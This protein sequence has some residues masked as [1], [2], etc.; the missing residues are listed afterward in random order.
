[1]PE[2]ITVD[3]AART[4]GYPALTAEDGAVGR[5]A[6]LSPVDAA[7]SHRA[8]LAQLFRIQQADQVKYVEKRP[9]LPPQLQLTLSAIDSD[10][11]SDLLNLSIVEALTRDGRIDILDADTFAVRAQDAR[12]VLYETVDENAGILATLME[13]REQLTSAIPD[14][15]A[16]YDTMHD[17]EMQL[18]FLFRPG[19]IQTDSVLSR[20]SRYLK[21][22]ELRIQRIRNNPQADAR[23]QAEIEPFQNRLNEKLLECDDIAG[24]FELIEFAMLL[25]EFRVNRFAPEIKT[26]V[27]VSAQRLDEAW[28][29][30]ND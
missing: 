23:K 14:L 2:F 27:K 5:R 3:D 6:F 17:L 15:S 19:F 13:Q 26:P 16:D 29:A 20:Y 22:M 10:F 8:G 12:S 7:Y 24:A 30:L 9:P 28:H 4:R 18:A 11:L 21:A 1:L 25:E